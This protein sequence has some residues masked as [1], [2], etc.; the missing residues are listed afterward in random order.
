M[1]LTLG[2]GVHIALTLIRALIDAPPTEL[3]STSPQLIPLLS[4]GTLAATCAASGL[5]LGSGHRRL[6]VVIDSVGLASIAYLTASAL[7]GPLL[8]GA[9]CAEAVALVQLWRASGD[10]LARFGALAFLGLAL[11]YTLVT[12]APPLALVTG[13]DDLGAAAVALGAIALAAARTGRAQTGDSPWRHRLLGSAAGA[14]L[15]LVSVAIVTAFQPGTETSAETILDLTVRQEGQVLLSALWSV[16][17]LGALVVGLRRRDDTVR[18]LA[19]AWL[20]VAVA[21]VFLYDLSTLT[22]IF[23]VTSFV[24]LGLL[25]LASSYA[26]QRLR[27]QSP[28]DLRTTHADDSGSEARPPERASQRKRRVVSAPEPIASSPRRRG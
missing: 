2:L 21:K 11:L 9:W 25:L 26:H 27:P 20:M 17:G 5:L 28:L 10:A 22:S 14:L 16:V 6:Q 18:R 23:R 7:S 13:V 4:V 15:Y 3:G 12:V 8:V 24:V 1:L 19:L